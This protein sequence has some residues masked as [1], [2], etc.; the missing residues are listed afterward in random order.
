MTANHLTP[1][2]YTAA[3]AA[4]ILRVK[5]SW[6]ERQ[7]AAS[8]RIRF[9]RAVRVRRRVPDRAPVRGVPAVPSR[10]RPGASRRDGGAEPRGGAGTG[11]GLLFTGEELTYPT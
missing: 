1:A 8:Q 4:E 10:L 7:A 11:H 2:L 3:E 6:L 9:G 5:Q